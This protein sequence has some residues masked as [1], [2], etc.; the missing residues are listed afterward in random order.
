MKLLIKLICN[1]NVNVNK[2]H[3][4][5]EQKINFRFFALRINGPD[6]YHQPHFI[7]AVAFCS[8]IMPEIDHWT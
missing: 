8:V 3:I 5:F 2:Y 4:L 1:L 6:L 7:A